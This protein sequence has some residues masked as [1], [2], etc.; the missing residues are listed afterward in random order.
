MI[1][2]LH[3]LPCHISRDPAASSVGKGQT[4]L[5]LCFIF[6]RSIG[7]SWCELDKA[8]IARAE[9]RAEFAE[10][11]AVR[12]PLAYHVLLTFAHPTSVSL[13]ERVALCNGWDACVLPLDHSPLA[14]SLTKSGHPALTIDDDGA[15]TVTLNDACIRDFQLSRLLQDGLVHVN[16]PLGLCVEALLYSFLFQQHQSYFAGHLDRIFALDG[17]RCAEL[18]IVAAE[19]AWPGGHYGKD[20][21]A[22]MYV[23]PIVNA[24]KAFLVSRVNPA[25]L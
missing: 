25:P 5:P 20:E 18:L 1:A 9:D 19:R 3:G 11:D 16:T 22:R 8:G 21:W 2:V 14:D 7:R 4:P 13:L 17:G 6:D 10:D 15:A 24:A 23:D 12:N